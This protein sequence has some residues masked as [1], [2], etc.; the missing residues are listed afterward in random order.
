ME[1]LKFNQL[2]TVTAKSGRPYTK[3]AE[4]SKGKLFVN[5]D[6]QCAPAKTEYGMMAC[7]HLAVRFASNGDYWGM[8]PREQG[9]DVAGLINLSKLLIPLTMCAPPTFMLM[10]MENQKVIP[11]MFD[12]LQSI[13]IANGATMALDVDALKGMVESRMGGL[14]DHDPFVPTFPNEKVKKAIAPPTKPKAEPENEE[15]DDEDE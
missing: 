9:S 6:F 14:P 15:A 3:F 7:H 8:S 13:A 4:G 11:R 1:Y 5:L 2:E 12:W 10:K